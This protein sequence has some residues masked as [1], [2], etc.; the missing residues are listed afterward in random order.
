MSGEHQKTMSIPEYGRRVFNWSK[1][2]S[3]AR[4]SHFVLIKIG[5]R[6]HVNVRASDIKLG[7]VEEKPNGEGASVGA[8]SQPAEQ[9]A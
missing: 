3:Y 4:K 8:T 2:T 6:Y 9:E 1:N 7:F 5:H